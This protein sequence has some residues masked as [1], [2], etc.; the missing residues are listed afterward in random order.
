LQNVIAT[1][2]KEARLK[3]DGLAWLSDQISVWMEI[4]L[5]K[6]RPFRNLE[7]NYKHVKEYKDK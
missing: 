7:A 5:E 4:N 1:L 3:N 2:L 6:T